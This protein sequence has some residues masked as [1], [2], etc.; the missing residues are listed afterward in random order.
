MSFSIVIE[1]DGFGDLKFRKIKD[2]T[3]TE[4]VEIKIDLFEWAS[5][6]WQVSRSH[7]IEKDFDAAN[8]ARVKW[9]EGK[10]YRVTAGVAN[11][12][13]EKT[14]ALTDEWKKKVLSPEN[15]NSETAE[16]TGGIRSLSQDSF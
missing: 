7:I 15:E 3:T 16:P 14:Q 4:F 8:Q 9:I 2:G 6:L 1:D 13:Y 11:A 12:I 10:G 5:G